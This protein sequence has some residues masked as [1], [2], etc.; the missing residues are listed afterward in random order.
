MCKVSVSISWSSV[1]QVHLCKSSCSLSHFY[2]G[3]YVYACMRLNTLQVD[4]LEDLIK[5]V[6]GVKYIDLE[7]HANPKRKQSF[8]ID[9][10]E[11]AST[12]SASV[13]KKS[14]M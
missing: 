14:E 11:Y 1:C 5:T 13:K 3:I 4:R 9:N 7:S 6:K 8:D 10:G 12:E 2:V